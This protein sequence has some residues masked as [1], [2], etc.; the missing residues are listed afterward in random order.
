MNCPIVERIR[1]R[2]GLYRITASALVWCSKSRLVGGWGWGVGVQRG[3]HRVTQSRLRFF[4]FDVGQ[5]DFVAFLFN[6]PKGDDS[7]S[8]TT[9]RTWKKC[10]FKTR[11]QLAWAL[12][13]RPGT[14]VKDS[15]LLS[16]SPSAEVGLVRQHRWRRGGIKIKQTRCLIDSSRRIS[17]AWTTFCTQSLCTA[18]ALFVCFFWQ[19]LA[20]QK[21]VIQFKVGFLSQHAVHV[22]QWN[23]QWWRR[24]SWPVF[25]G[26]E[27]YVAFTSS[28]CCSS[29]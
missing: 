2:P 12:R 4:T 18:C 29:T 26:T 21:Q 7:S 25:H 11:L 15:R 14:S 3:S 16:R 1:S 27:H 22:L 23:S 20:L 9:K 10:D 24:C 8:E 19:P 13:R 6:T 17:C 28:S 5:P